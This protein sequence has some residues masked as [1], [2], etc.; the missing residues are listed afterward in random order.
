MVRC[1]ATHL[2][3]SEKVGETVP[4]ALGSERILRSHARRTAGRPR[5][6]VG[7]F[8]HPDGN[9]Y[10]QD[11]TIDMYSSLWRCILFLKDT[12]VTL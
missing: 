12:V 9:T 4:A 8:P 5:S 7:A 6:Q 2:L 3:A 11:N 1:V 10:E